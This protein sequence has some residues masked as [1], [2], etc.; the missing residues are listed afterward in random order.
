MLKIKDIHAKIEEKSILN[1]I[2][3]E[4]KPG[5]VHA[6]MGPNGSGKSTLASVIT[7][8]EEYEITKGKILFEKE[9]LEEVS[10]EERAH[11]GIFMSFQYPIEIPGVTIT[12]FL[13]TAINETKKARGE[14]E[15]SAKD[16]LKM[17]REK[18]NMLEIDGKF[19]SRS[20][21]DGFSGGEKK[22]NEIFQMAML[23]PKLAILD[24]T[25]SGLDIDALKIVAN[26]VNKL[27][28]NDNAILVITH[29][30]RLL[31]Y[32]VPD[33]V[34]V[35]FDGKIVKSG[36]KELALKLEEKGYDWIKEEAK[37]N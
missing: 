8:K 25:D 12:N 11:K 3:L 21:N 26:G 7:G 34:H 15:M 17:L 33:Y 9:D 19:L 22:R 29:Y 36:G 30:Q 32:I 24:E 20:I 14:K 13:K 18:S 35:L 27:K 28:N 5:E 2:N 16:M 6:I 1:G 37:N 31:E 4:I 10:P 23:E